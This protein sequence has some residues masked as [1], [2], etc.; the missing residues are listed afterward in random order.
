MS[1]VVDSIL[2]NFDTEGGFE[3]SSAISSAVFYGFV[4]V[5]VDMNNLAAEVNI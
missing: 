4:K 5:T 1:P 3:S 2:A